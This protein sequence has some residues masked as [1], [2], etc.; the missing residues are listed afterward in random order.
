MQNFFKNFLFGLGRWGGHSHW[1]IPPMHHM[2]EVGLGLSW[3]PGTQFRSPTGV[4]ETQSHEVSVAGFQ[5][6]Q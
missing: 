3:E 4:V 2:T 5:G 1:L 6:A